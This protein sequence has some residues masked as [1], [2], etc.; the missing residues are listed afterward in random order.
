MCGPA[1]PTKKEKNKSVQLNKGLEEVKK[2]ATL[3]K[4]ENKILGLP[5][6]PTVSS[7]VE[8]KK[9]EDEAPVPSLTEFVNQKLKRLQDL[10]NDARSPD[11]KDSAELAFVVC[12]QV[13]QKLVT[14][15]S[16]KTCSVGDGVFKDMSPHFVEVLILAG[17]NSLGDNLQ[18]AISKFKAKEIVDSYKD[19]QEGLIKLVQEKI[20]NLVS[21]SRG[22]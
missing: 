4:V 20:K 19:D 18:S 1:K 7:H 8:P 15:I 21:R 14:S 10:T 22:V 2:V 16:S 17:L 9:K 11:N 3:T 12:G 13:A 6:Y 5:V